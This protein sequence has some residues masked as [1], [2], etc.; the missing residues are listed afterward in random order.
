LQYISA[1][2][3]GVGKKQ[4]RKRKRKK[5]SNGAKQS[6]QKF[7][8]LVLLYCDEKMWASFLRRHFT[9]PPFATTTWNNKPIFINLPVFVRKFST[10]KV[11]G[12]G[13]S[14]TWT[15]LEC[16]RHTYV[17]VIL[18]SLFIGFVHVREIPRVFMALV[19]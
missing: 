13:P 14:P 8:E 7:W 15:N 9:S 10:R 6:T 18:G 1:V 5:Q 4:E 3:D 17:V 12:S 11:S 16:D 2:S 19:A